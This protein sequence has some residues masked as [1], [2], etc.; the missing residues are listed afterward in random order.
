MA[1]LKPPQKI[2]PATKLAIMMTPRLIWTGGFFSVF[3][4]VAIIFIFLTHYKMFRVLS[5]QY[6]EARRQRAAASRRQTRS[7]PQRQHL[8]V[9]P[10]LLLRSEEHTSELQSRPHLVCRLLLEI[11]Y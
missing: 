2:T 3:H 1:V 5:R 7:R 8:T 4:S 10:E 9:V 6:L 11:N